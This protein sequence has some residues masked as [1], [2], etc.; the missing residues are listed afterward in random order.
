MPLPQID[1]GAISRGSQDALAARRAGIEDRQLEQEYAIQ[2]R[3]RIMRQDVGDALARGDFDGAA[4]IAAR[5][6]DIDLY[7]RIKQL[8]KH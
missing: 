4:N 8:A 7:M 3:N 6:G 5:A 1:Y 2:Q